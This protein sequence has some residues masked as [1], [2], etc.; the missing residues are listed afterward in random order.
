MAKKASDMTL[1]E[2]RPDIEEQYNNLRKH[3]KEMGLLGKLKL[4]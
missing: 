2:R 3:L 4:F 1:F